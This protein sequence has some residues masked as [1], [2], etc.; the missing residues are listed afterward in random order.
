MPLKD[1]FEMYTAILTDVKKWK[2]ADV[3][4]KDVL[5]KTIFAKLFKHDFDLND[6]NSWST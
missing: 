1:M 3:T 5:E 4:Y 6:L 2:N